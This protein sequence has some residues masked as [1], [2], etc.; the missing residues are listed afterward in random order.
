MESVL[1]KTYQRSQRKRASERNS[2]YRPNIIKWRSQGKKEWVDLKALENPRRSIK[3]Y[4]TVGCTKDNVGKGK[5]IIIIDC[6]TENGPVPGALWIFS[7]GSKSQ[8]EKQEISFKETAVTIEKAKETV[9]AVEEQDSGPKNVP[10]TSTT[11]STKRKSKANEPLAKSKKVK[12]ATD[13]KNPLNSKNND[14][15]GNEQSPENE[16]AGIIEE[17]DYH[18]SMNAENYEKY[19]EKICKLLKPNS[20]TIIDNASYHSRNSDDYPKSKWKKAQFEQWLKENK[21]NFP[22]DALRSEL[23][24]LCKTHRN[25]KNAKVVEK[26]AKYGMEVLRLPPYHCELNAIELIWADKKNVVA[27]ENKEMTIEHVETLFRKRR[28]EI[29]AET[30]KNCIKH[31]RFV[32]EEYWK[33]DRIMDKKLE[34]FSIS[35]GGSDTE[36]VD[37]DTDSDDTDEAE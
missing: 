12:K 16:D 6:I 17:F 9:Q 18:D 37:L 20:L 13:T 31:A 2:L 4:G 23:W 28:E 1:F 21:V 26:I 29:S 25:E 11:R 27:R 7:A 36:T 5:R 30:C 35:V 14:V 33:T 32:E 24:V 22:S 10:S 8:K 34:K 3:E 15:D 19:F